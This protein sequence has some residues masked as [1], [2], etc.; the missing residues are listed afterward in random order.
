VISPIIKFLLIVLG[1]AIV[2]FIVYIGYVFYA[3]NSFGDGGKNY[4]TAE[5]VKNFNDKRIEIYNV[6]AYI[7]KIAPKYKL[8]E[9]EF[10]SDD[11]IGR[12]VITPKDTG[13]GSNTAVEFEDWNLKVNSKKVDSLLRI[14][15][16]NNKTLENLKENLDKANCISID[17]GEPAKIGFK[18]NGLG[19]FFFNVFDNP[20]PYSLKSQYNDSC[21]YIYANDKLVLE[22]GGGA[23]GR[24]CFFNKTK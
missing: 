14:L 18:R 20:I 2:C 24:Q 8:I 21:T 22:Y 17:N 12:L 15:G 6:K 5:L 10:N 1:C 7:N 23:I 11:E 9:I 16:W 4:S 3:F 19:M 13:R